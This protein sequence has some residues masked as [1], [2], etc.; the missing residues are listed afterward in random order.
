LL[1]QRWRRIDEEHSFGVVKAGLVAAAKR[2]LMPSRL[3][4][5]MAH[6]LLAALNE[7][8]LLIATASDPKR[9]ER[10]ALGALDLLLEW[11]LDNAQR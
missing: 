3:V 2:K 5:P 9:A 6:I 10:E 1:N 11:L 8:A 4:E 7:L